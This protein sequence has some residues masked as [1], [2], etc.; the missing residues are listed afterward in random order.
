MSTQPVITTYAYNQVI[1]AAYADAENFN[2]KVNLPMVKNE[3]NIYRNSSQTILLEVRSLSRKLLQIFNQNFYINI[4]NNV[5]GEL[6]FRRAGEVF[7]STPGRLKFTFG[8]NDFD[9]VTPGMY[10]FSVSI[11]DETGAETFLFLDQSGGATGTLYVNDNAFPAFVPS[12]VANSFT[13][14]MDNPPLYN[15]YFLSSPYPGNGQFNYI[16]GQHTITVYMT[17]YTGT[18]TVQGTLAVAPGE[19]DWFDCLLTEQDTFVSYSSF[20]G[21][22]CYNFQG[23][24]QWVR[25][26]YDPDPM[27]NMGS[28]DQVLYRGINNPKPTELT[29]PYPKL[30]HQKQYDSNSGQPCDFDRGP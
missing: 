3:V 23:A 26:R 9:M 20:T 11:V 2:G 19:F 30:P 4:L 13:R 8:E 25:F 27:L 28:L 12:M 10:N 1:Y 6:M 7:D 21:I 29:Q 18:F 24:L 22:D 17:N 14:R 16:D 15:P 5:T